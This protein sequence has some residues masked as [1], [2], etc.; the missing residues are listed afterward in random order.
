VNDSIQI[1]TLNLEQKV[2]DLE[3]RFQDCQTYLNKLIEKGGS[4][5]GF[6]QQTNGFNLF[7]QLFLG[8]LWWMQRELQ[9]AQKY[10]PKKKQVQVNA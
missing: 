3:N 8:A 5:Q 2:R 4:S 10:L 6:W 7:L 1:A 9:E